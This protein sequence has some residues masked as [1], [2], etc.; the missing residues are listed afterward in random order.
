[1][2]SQSVPAVSAYRGLLAPAQ[3]EKGG[4]QKIKM[5]RGVIRDHPQVIPEN[6]GTGR[7][8][9]VKDQDCLPDSLPEPVYDDLAGSAHRCSKPVTGAACAAMHP[10]NINLKPLP[11]LLKTTPVKPGGKVMSGEFRTNLMNYS[12]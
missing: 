2:G 5:E 6:R 9:Q 7:A 10:D 8:A 12:G 3:V 11:Y 4:T 1:M